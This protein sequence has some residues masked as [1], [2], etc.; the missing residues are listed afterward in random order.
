MHI[1]KMKHLKPLPT[2]FG[3]G[4]VLRSRLREPRVEIERSSGRVRALRLGD[5]VLAEKDTVISGDVGVG[6][7]LS[8]D[9]SV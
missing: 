3:N 7:N 1:R 9:G 5:E 4:R 8:E 2:G 6:E